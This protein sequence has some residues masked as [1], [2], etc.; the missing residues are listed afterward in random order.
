MT[1]LPGVYRPHAKARSFALSTDVLALAA[2]AL[3]FGGLVFAVWATWGD[4]GRDTGYDLVAGSRVAHGQL[5]YVDF[6]YYYGP[7]APMLLGLAGWIGQ[8]LSNPTDKAVIDRVRGQV[9]EL[10]KSFPAPA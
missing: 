4:L 9:K 10:G 3:L 7:L 5:P 1:A 8:V 2:L 6:V